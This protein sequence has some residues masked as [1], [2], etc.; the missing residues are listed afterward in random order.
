MEVQADK[1]APWFNQPR[2]GMQYM[3]P[4]TVDELLNPNVGV[5]RRLQ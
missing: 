5:L 4:D 1:I 3:L 2:G